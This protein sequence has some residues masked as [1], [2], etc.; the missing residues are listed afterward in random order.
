VSEKKQGQWPRPLE[1]TALKAQLDT[2]VDRANDAIE[3]DA[4]ERVATKAS[5]KKIIEM[6]RGGNSVAAM[7]TAIMALAALTEE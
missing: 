6:L 5:L 2:L 4:A 3:R 1:A 7:E